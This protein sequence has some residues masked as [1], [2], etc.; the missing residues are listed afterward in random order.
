MGHHG[1]EEAH[2]APPQDFRGVL[3]FSQ[4]KNPGDPD[5]VPPKRMQ[6]ALHLRGIPGEKSGTTAR[7]ISKPI[8]SQLIPNQPGFHSQLAGATFPIS[9]CRIPN[10]PVR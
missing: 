7:A 8:L 5:P 10:Q 4:W 6:L 1:L 3:S 2:A 9:R